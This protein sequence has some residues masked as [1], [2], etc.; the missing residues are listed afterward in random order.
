MKQ[1]LLII[2]FTIS[3]QRITAQTATCAVLLDSLKG[4]YEGDCKNGKANGNGKAVG[5]NTYDGEFKNGVPEGNGKYTWTSGDYYYGGWKKGLKDGKGQLH[6]FEN[7]IETLITG[8][9][10][11]GN[12]KGEYKDPYVITNT[13]SE[14][15]RVEVTK[16]SSEDASI[17]ITVQNLANNSSFQSSTFNNNNTKM[18]AHQV[19][20]GSYVSKSNTALTNK[21]VTT[22]REVVFPFRCTFN[23]G[24]S[25]VEIEFFEKGAWDVTVPINK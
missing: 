25:I 19:I 8:Y 2:F 10:R 7:G 21:E 22:F 14:V 24:N 9:W 18:T 13:T 23:F 17:T 11:N 12:Y 6:R 4:T 1:L 3:I 16:M 5:I 15:G 20:R